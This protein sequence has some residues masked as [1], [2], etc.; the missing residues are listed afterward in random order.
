VSVSL[1]RAPLLFV[2]PGQMNAEFPLETPLGSQTVVVAGPNGSSQAY[3]VQVAAAAPAI[4]FSPVPAVLK[5]AD[6]SLVSAANPAKPGDVIL[7]YCTGLGQT[8]PALTTGMGAAAGVVSYTAPLTATM[9][10][11]AATVIYS[12]ASPGFPGLYQV[13]VTVPA[14]LTGST[15]LV[16]S[17]T[18]ATS[19]SVNIAL[20]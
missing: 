6:Y 18:G 7:V 16:L 13:A 5:N 11:K 10:G 4:F 15:P 17:E 1:L 14:G 2:S 12:I 8:T 19:N 9:G 20:K 3:T